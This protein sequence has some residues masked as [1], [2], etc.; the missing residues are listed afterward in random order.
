M[1]ELFLAVLVSIGAFVA[2]A[3]VTQAL[4]NRVERAH[5]QRNFKSTDCYKASIQQVIDLEQRRKARR[6]A[7]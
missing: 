4:V 7:N 3:L 1:I 2:C 5:F 6:N